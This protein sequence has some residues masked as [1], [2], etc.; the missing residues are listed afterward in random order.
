MRGKRAPGAARESDPL[1]RWRKWKRRGRGG[2]ISGTAM[3]PEEWQKVKELC[4]LALEQPREQRRQ[5]LADACPDETLRREVESMIARATESDGILE[6]PIW[7]TSRIPGT[8][9]R[10]RVLQ[11]VGEG[12]MGAV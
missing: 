7:Q 4:Q 12:G 3:A 9:G 8:L 5:F 10:Y 1:R 2:M 6:A 11:L